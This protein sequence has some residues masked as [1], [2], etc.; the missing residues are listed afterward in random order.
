LLAFPNVNELKHSLSTSSDKKEG[1]K[2][3]TQNNMKTKRKYEK[4]SM[5][6]VLLQ[7][8]QQLLQSSLPTD[9]STSPYQW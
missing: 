8:S 3:M 2:I 6:V 9:P 5:Q 4:P 1:E 7:Q